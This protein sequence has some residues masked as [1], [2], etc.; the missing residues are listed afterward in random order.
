MGLLGFEPRDIEMKRVCHSQQGYLN[1]NTA[2]FSQTNLLILFHN[3]RQASCNY[4]KR[5]TIQ[6]KQRKQGPLGLATAQ[7]KYFKLAAI[8][9][10]LRIQLT[11]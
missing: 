5:F 1:T 11:A 8:S 6:L 3:M 10:H 2:Y 7:N 9:S 4:E